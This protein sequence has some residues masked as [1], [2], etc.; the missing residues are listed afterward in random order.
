MIDFHC[1]LDLFRDPRAVALSL[2]A[3]QIY[4]LSV[5][6]TPKAF[7][8]TKR[9][10]TDCP[11]I[12]TALGLHPQLAH[13]RRSELDL[14]ELLLPET[15]YVGE[16]GLDGSP[17]FRQYFADQ[18]YVFETILR[19]CADA[20]G[21]VM[22]IHSRAAATNVLK[23]LQS[24]P[25]AGLPI[26]HWFSGTRNELDEAIAI[27]AWFSVGPAMLRSKKGREL[28]ARMP[29][30]RVLTETDAPFA[31]I[32]SRPVEHADLH[33]AVD[34]LA[35]L[36]HCSTNDAHKQLYSNLKS[37]SKTANSLMN[38]IRV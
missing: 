28:T 16:I 29:K 4:T 14:F 8:G 19:L 25:G 34:S 1:H 23:A 27:G 37:I 9:F 7:L 20:G 32:R 30:N 18:S 13:Q 12:R 36:W 2:R 22:S 11:R 24:F 26:F 21:R 38:I 33:D 31:A 17:D 15:P 3:E 35:E 6:T 10:A 5:T